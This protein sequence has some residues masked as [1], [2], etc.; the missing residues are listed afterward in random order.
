MLRRK[1]TVFPRFNAS[2]LLRLSPKLGSV[3]MTG[4][5]VAVCIGTH[6]AAAQQQPQPAAGQ[7]QDTAARQDSNS[8]TERAR[9]DSQLQIAQQ[10]AGLLQMAKD[11]KAELDM[12]SSDT[13]SVAAF[14]KADAIERLTQTVKDHNKHPSRKP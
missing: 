6:S 12:T 13:L 5:V 1:S 2:I 14:R 11:L 9:S 7:D 10:S 3:L 4:F 8:S